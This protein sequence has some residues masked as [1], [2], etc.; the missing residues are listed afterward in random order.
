MQ[1]K[2][3][4]GKRNFF[5]TLVML[6]LILSA[7]IHA[8]NETFRMNQIDDTTTVNLGYN[9]LMKN[10]STWIQTKINRLNTTY[11]L[12]QPILDT[13]EI[14][15][16]LRK[17]SGSNEMIRQNLRYNSITLRVRQVN[18]LKNEIQSEIT[19]LQHLQK[20]VAQF[21]NYLLQETTNTMT[22]KREIDYFS[23]HADS[24]IL[25]IYQSELVL[26]D[27]TIQKSTA[28]FSSQ[29]ISLVRLEDSINLTALR[30]QE[31]NKFAQNLINEIRIQQR[32][33]SF[34]PI[35]K[36]K[37]SDY[38]R[39]FLSTVQDTMYQAYDSITFFLKHNITRLIL[40]RVLIFILCLIPIH[41]YRKNANKEPKL[42]ASQKYLQKYP[43]LT[44]LIMGLAVAPLIFTHAPYAFLDL[45]FISMT[46]C[47]SI[48]YVKENTQIARIPFFI[49]LGS[50]ILLKLINFF[51]SPTFAGRLIFSFAIFL[52][53]PMY[54]IYHNMLVKKSDQPKIF[55]IIYLILGLQ[56]VYGWILVMLGYYP[57]GR[58]FYLGAI[59]AFILA[60]I[61]TV[62]VY[63]FI[64]YLR[65][66][67]FMINKNSKT[68]HINHDIVE[69]N[70]KNIVIGLAMFYFVVSYLKNINIYDDLATSFFRNLNTERQL[71]D[72]VFT[73]SSIILFFTIIL[74]SIYIANLINTA[75]D[76]ADNKKQFKNRTS[77]GSIMLLL[78]FFI[79]S[80]GFIVGIIASG[81]PVNQI[82]VLM[83]ALG[84]GIGFGLQ[85]IFN[86]LVS[87]L[88]IA[89]EKPVSVGDM[90]EL[91]N[92]TGWIKE[93]GI[94]SSNLQTYDGAEVIVPNGELIS[95]KVTNWTLSN[96][97]RRMELPI[98]VSYKSDPHIV[99]DLLQQI[100][101][102]HHEIMKNP[103]P[104]LLFTGL[105]ESS[106]NFSMYFWV[107]DFVEAKR[108]RSEV[109]FRVFDV[110]KEHQIEIPFPQQDIHLYT[111]QGD[112][113]NTMPK[114][115]S[116]STI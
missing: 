33:F 107:S 45:I 68:I 113:V 59:D 76:T 50:F 111:E 104:Y 63:T 72:S 42:F 93:I 2:T 34:P 21:N 97:R 20:K 28:L 114:N 47:V 41:F 52:L 26:L 22:I 81:I 37:P 17:I 7:N 9:D 84:V 61:L 66:I 51:T 73:F 74:G 4:S 8:Q 85:N 44:N 16:K 46:I 1:M 32:T 14:I 31:T 19:D 108:I 49:L 109:L 48:I 15:K 53:L 88:I 30:L 83:G 99:R 23:K 54:S 86:N 106:L 56:L 3:G 102:E 70:F 11:V 12:L 80:V 18:D 101:N 38:P 62:I 115:S 91:G 64:D 98:G 67:T 77:F 40:Y 87:G 36:S 100:L 82:T 96:K 57:L 60:L 103:E 94:R 116:K 13:A 95:N 25:H 24:I 71:G 43:T 78:R 29:L 55:R 27:T 92:D 90:V 112:S 35:W 58:Q 89:I 79:I 5:I 69:N 65:I 6:I 10:P 110:L 105:G 75:L 39:T